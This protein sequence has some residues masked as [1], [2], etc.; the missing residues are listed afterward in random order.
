MRKVI[1]STELAIATL[2]SKEQLAHFELVQMIATTMVTVLMDP[3][4]VNQDTVVWTALVG[5]APMIAQAEE[6]VT[7]MCVSVMKASWDSTAH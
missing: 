6:T 2:A 5:L 1:A 4:D 3:A 7:N